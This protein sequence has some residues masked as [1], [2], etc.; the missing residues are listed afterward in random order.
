MH[1]GQVDVAHVGCIVVVLDCASGPVVGLENEVVTRLD[2]AGHRNVRMP[3]VVDLLVLGGRLIQVDLD[4]GIGHDEAP[5]RWKD[6]SVA[7]NTE[8]VFSV[9]SFSEIRW[10]TYARSQQMRG[11]QLCWAGR[12]RP[13]C[14]ECT[15]V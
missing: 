1:G 13:A 6:I 15:P 3:A 14:R 4:Q 5:L 10:M 2:P 9:A 8:L 12:R 11:L 7:L